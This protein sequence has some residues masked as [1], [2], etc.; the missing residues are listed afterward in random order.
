MLAHFDLLRD[1]WAVSR[2]KPAVERTSLFALHVGR[3]P[4]FMGCAKVGQRDEVAGIERVEA[5]K[6]T[7]L[8]RAAVDEVT[9]MLGS[10][11]M[12]ANTTIEYINLVFRKRDEETAMALSEIGQKC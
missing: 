4:A 7:R 8:A 3:H 5:K 1:D 11:A 9:N 10:H 12:R 6:D 2:N